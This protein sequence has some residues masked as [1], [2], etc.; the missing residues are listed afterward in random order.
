MQNVDLSSPPDL[1]THSHVG[2][3]Q[4][5]ANSFLLLCRRAA[6]TGFYQRTRTLFSR[7]AATVT[8]RTPSLPEIFQE[9]AIARLRAAGANIRDIEGLLILPGLQ[10]THPN[11]RSNGNGQ[12]E[13]A[14]LRRPLAKTEALLTRLEAMGVQAQDLTVHKGM[15]PANMT[16]TISYLL[17]DIPQ[18]PGQVAICDQLGQITFVSRTIEPPEF[19]MHATKQQLHAHSDIIRIRYDGEGRWLDAVQQAL[20]TDGFIE[21]LKHR[22]TGALHAATTRK[23]RPKKGPLSKDQIRK[24]LV[25]FHEKEGH[26]P[27]AK[28]KIVWQKNG[29]GEWTEVAGESWKLIDVA[30]YQGYRGFPG[31]GSLGRLKEEWGFSNDLPP[32]MLAQWMRDFH[33]KEG[34][35][36]TTA[37]PTVWRKNDED[38]WVAMPRE[39][40][41][42]I[43]G[44]LRKGCRGWSGG[45]SLA[46]FKQERGFVSKRPENPGQESPASGLRL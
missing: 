45:S 5:F 12:D 36:P 20:S 9:D 26:Y 15:T 31:K 30:L 46:I 27:S 41:S 3:R 34:R 32:E 18:I 14:D 10:T 2:L 24:W 17:I 16:R 23:P 1:Q 21:K 7:A 6:Q 33:E 42:A 11:F 19:W 13:S 35:Y 25:L 44:T 43:D 8:H 38:L 39:T 4:R 22:R 28:D 37:D 29:D 40:W